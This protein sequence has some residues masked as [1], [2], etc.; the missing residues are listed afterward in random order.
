MAPAF[1][2]QRTRP[3]S[4][5]GAVIGAL[6]GGVG[7]AVVAMVHLTE[8]NTV[9]VPVVLGATLIG[10]GIGAIAG[11][12]RR[13]SIAA[14]VGAG[15]SVLVFLL[16]LPVV[17]LFALLGVGTRPT[18]VAMVAIGALSGLAGAL[19]MRARPGPGG[20]V[21]QSWSSRGGHR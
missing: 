2:P 6:V 5:R 13:A 15:L 4:L 1:R 19:A 17:S 18:V 12:V 8:L 10:G 3:S 14:A 9:T 21:S 7:R 11:L 16:T 20:I